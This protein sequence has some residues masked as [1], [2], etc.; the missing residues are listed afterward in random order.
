M[1]MTDTNKTIMT[2]RQHLDDN[3]SL[4]EEQGI[5]EIVSPAGKNL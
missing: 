4:D 3:Q 5:I 1:K 2:S